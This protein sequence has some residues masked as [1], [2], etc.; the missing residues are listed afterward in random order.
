MIIQKAKSSGSL[1][2]NNHEVM[3]SWV[4]I[5]ERSYCVFGRVFK[6]LLTLKCSNFVN[7]NRKG[8]ILQQD[9]PRSDCA[10]EKNNELG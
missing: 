6:E 4:Y 7:Y 1:Q 10:L 8:V 5:P 2:M 9:N 3:R